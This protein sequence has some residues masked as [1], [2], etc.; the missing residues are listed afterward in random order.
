MS[1]TFVVHRSR[2]RSP[3]SENPF[4][5]ESMNE[6][7][8]CPRHL[9]MAPDPGEIIAALPYLV[10]FP[11]ISAMVAVLLDSEGTLLMTARHDWDAVVA[12]P[13]ELAANLVDYAQQCGC[14]SVALIAMGP[15]Q[16]PG[17]QESTLADFAGFLD[18]YGDRSPGL[19]QCRAKHPGANNRRG[20]GLSGIAGMS[21]TSRDN[22]VAVLWAVHSEADRWWAAECRHVC[23]PRSH[24]VPS[25]EDSRLVRLLAA[26]GREPAKTRQQIIS[27]FE[28]A[29]EVTVAEVADAVNRLA[30]ISP[31]PDEALALKNSMVD[32]AELLLLTDSAMSP[33]DVATLVVVC[34]D[35]RMRDSALWRFTD[36]ATADPKI[37]RRVWPRIKQALA[38][39][40]ESHVAAVAAVA[41]LFA[42]QNGDGI[43]AQ[44]ALDR[45]LRQDPTHGLANLV[46]QAVAG[47]LPPSA[48]ASAMRNLTEMECMKGRDGM[49]GRGSAKGS[50]EDTED[51]EA[52]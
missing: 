15:T 31:D 36:F 14:S 7:T 9:E 34:Q 16:D 10:G 49:I 25:S 40:P 12:A 26:D 6:N 38:S 23:G 27:E 4:D 32:R 28:P 50:E 13:A 21:G 42:W 8:P 18:A 35:I 19:N 41:G 45:A 47:G 37:W 17:T 2:I 1:T 44:A 39:A 33:Q 3:G 51:T 29:S 20:R 5:I 11:P 52:A 46:H 24:R 30:I 43:R 22:T 48:W